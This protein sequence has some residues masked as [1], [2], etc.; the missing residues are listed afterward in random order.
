MLQ[1]MPMVHDLNEQADDLTSE[2]I[3]SFPQITGVCLYGSVARGDAGPDSDLDLLVVGLD[4][5]LTPSSIKRRLRLKDVKPRVSIVYHTPRTLDRYAMTG[6]RFLL[7]VQL[8]GKVLYDQDGFLGRLKDRPLSKQSA[9]AEVDG[10]LKRLALYDDASR[11]NGNFLFPLSHIYAIGKAIVMAILA[12]N[13]IYEF[14]RDRAF[15]AFSTLFPESLNDV[16]TVARLR[17]FYSMV[18]K[19]QDVE[20]P[21][22]YHDCE[23]EVRRA[24]DAVRRLAEHLQRD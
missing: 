22:A 24:T 16:A 5:T 13:E 15:D 3:H 20:L 18:S 8:E 7:H 1:S 23:Q 19:G 4:P 10:Q 9:A 21:F 6:S 11:Y 17:P 14:N 2:I 12:E